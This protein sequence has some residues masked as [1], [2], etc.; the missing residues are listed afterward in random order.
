[1][2]AGQTTRGAPTFEKQ[3]CSALEPL[4]FAQPAAQLRRQLRGLHAEDEVLLIDLG[5]VRSPRSAG[6]LVVWCARFAARAA[7]PSL[8]PWGADAGVGGGGHRPDDAI[9]YTLNHKCYTASYCSALS[10]LGTMRSVAGRQS[11]ML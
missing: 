8:C 3:F 7:L 2:P 11:I 5:H 10:D 6:P 9:F 1:L 4:L